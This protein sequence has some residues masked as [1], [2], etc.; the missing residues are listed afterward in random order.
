MKTDS[1]GLPKIGGL[2]VHS[3]LKTE[4]RKNH[5]AIAFVQTL[6]QR[7]V[8]LL[9][10]VICGYCATNTASAQTIFTN[11][12]TGTNPNTSNPYTTGQTVD[13]NI[14]VSGIGRG[15]GIVSANANDRYSASGWNSSFDA[16]DYFEWTLTP[17]SGYK[18][19]F[20][21]FVY[22]GQASGTGP[23]GFAFRASVDGFTANI[24][25]PAAAATT[26][27]LADSAYQ[28]ITEAITFRLYGFG[29]SQSGGTFSVNNF[30]FNGTVVSTCIIPTAFNVTGGG[31][32]CSGGAGVPIGL[33]NSEPGVNYQLFRS[34]GTIAVGAFVEG[35]G[36]AISFGNQ[37][38]EDTYTVVATNTTGNCTA[39]M[40]GSAVVTVTSPVTPSVT[41]SANPGTTTCAGNPVIFTATPVNGGSSPTYVWKTNG[42]QDTSVPVDSA[43][44]TNSNLADGETIDCQMTSS[45]TCVTTPTA[46]APQ[47]TMTIT[48]SVTPSVSVAANQGTTICAGSPV[49]FTATP[50]NGGSSPVYVWKTNGVADTSVPATSATYTN[51]SLGN[52]D[53]IDCQLISNDPCASPATADALQISMTVNATVTPSVTIE[54]NPGSTICPDSSVTFTATPVNG[55]VAPT[56]Q[57]RTNGV[58]VTDATSSTWMTSTLQNGDVVTV[59]VTP[60]GE[61]CVSP[62]TAVSEGITMTV[63]PR[64]TAIVSGT[65]AICE[66]SSADL[67]ATL[68]GNQPWSITWSDGVTESGITTSPHTRSVSPETNT[69]YTITA[70]SDANCSFTGTGSA[71]ITVNSFELAFTALSENMGTPSSTTLVND[72]TGWQSEPPITFSSTSSVQTDVRTTTASTGYPGASG[73]GNV[74]FGTAGGADRD[75]II[76]GINTMGLTASQLQFGLLATGS[77]PFVV[78]VSSDG[79]NWT[80]LTVPQPGSLNT[81]TLTTASGTIPAVPNLRIK[82]SKNSAT[83]QYRL[84]DVKLID[85]VDSVTI[86]ASGP[87]TFCDGGSVTLTA[88]GGGVSYLWSTSET[89][90]SITVNSSGTYSVTVFDAN[91]CSSTADQTV[92]VSSLPAVSVNSATICAGASAT[93]TATT[94]AS[95]PSYLWS[96]GGETT[97]SILVSPEVTTVYSVIVTDGT[98]GCASAATNTV[99]VNPLP[100]VAITPTATNAECGSTFTLTADVSGD[101]P[102]IY[103]WYDNLTNAI[104]N[105]T[106]ITLTLSDVDATVAGHYSIVVNG[107]FCSASALATVSVTDTLGPVIT[108][109]GPN[110]ATNE[111]HAAYLD[112]GAAASDACAGVV[113]V[114]TN[115]TVDVNVPGIYT[116]TYTSDDGNGNTNTATRTVYVQD[117]IAPLITYYFTNLTLSANGSC[118][119]LM[120]DV[121]GPDYVLAE[122][123]CGE[124]TITQT[125][126]N[127]ALLNLGPNEVV[128]IVTDSAGNTAYATNTIN[129]VDLTPPALVLNGDNPLT[130]ECHSPFAD[131]GASA[132]DNCSG[133]LAVTTNGVVDANVPGSY[134]IEYRAADAA[135]N[136]VTNTRVVNVVDTVPPVIV[137]GTNKAV[138]CGV[139]W[140]FDEPTAEDACAGVNVIVAI[141]DTV[142]NG[143]V[144]TRTWA[145]SDPAGNTNTCSQSVAVAEATGVVVVPL[146]ANPATNECHTTYSDPGALATTCDGSVAVSTNGTVDV[147]TP[148]VYTITYTA[149]DGDGHTNSATRTVYVVDTTAPLITFYFTNLTLN[150]DASCE[151][152]MPDVTDTNYILAEDLCSGEVTITQSPTNG[153]ALVL[154]T[155][156][157]VLAVADSAGNTAYS[158]N[159]IVVV[160]ATGPVVTINGDNPLTL[161]CHADFV[162]PGAIASDGCSGVLAVN[163]NGVVD[164]NVPGSYAIE[165]TATDSAGNSTTNTRIVNVVDATAPVVTVLGDNPATNE[166]H[167]VYVDAGATASDACAGSVAV[168][169]NHTVDANTPGVYTITYTAD[170]GNGNTNSATR[171]VYVVDT[172]PPQIVLCATNRTMEVVDNCLLALPDFTGELSVTDSCSEVFIVQNPTPGTLVGVGQLLVTFT[173]SDAALNSSTCS[174]LLNVTPPAGANTNLS[175]SEFMAKNTVVITDD[176]GVYSDWIEIHNAGSC[177]VN[178]AGWSLTDDSGSLAKWQFPATNIGPGQFM[179][180]WASDRNLSIPGAPLHTNFKLSDEGEYL[181]LVQPN[182]TPISQFSPVFPPQLP[183]VS[184]GLP[185]DRT[186]NTFLAAATPGAANSVATNFMGST[187]VIISEFMAKNTFTL[188]DEDGDYS[189]WIEIYNAGDS[190]VD[191]NGWSL[192]DN[193]AQLTKWRFPATNIA[194]GQFVLVWASDKNRRV[195]GAPLH[196]NFKMSDE[197]E[198]LALVQ[199]DG[200]TIATEF[201]PTFPPQFPDVSFG[202]PSGGGTYQFLASSTPGSANSSGTNFIVADLEFNPGRGWYKH[203]VSVTIGT[204]TPDV[205]IYWTTDG[206]VPSP[207]N[208]SL[209]TGPLLFSDTTVLRAAAYRPGYLPTVA[210]H[211]YVFPRQVTNQTGAGFPS[212]WGISYAGVR[213]A[214]YTCNSNL[215]NDPRWGSRMSTAL[216]TLP[217]LSV[218]MNQDDMF[219]TNGIYSN[220]FGDGVEWE[221]PCSVEYFRP[222]GENYFGPEPGLGFQI[223]CG[224]RIQGSSSRDPTF[225]PKHNLRLLFKQ[226]YDATPMIYDLYPGSP[227]QEFKTLVLHASSGDHWFGVGATAQMHRDQWVADTQE[228]IGDFGT[229]GVYVHLYINGLY[230]G[231]YNVGERPDVDYAVSY[232]GG[233]K[234]DYDIFNGE[235]LKDGTTNALNEMLTIARAGITN[236]VAW[237]NICHYLDVPSFINYL[238]INWYTINHDFTGHNY[239]LNGSVSHG[240]PFHFITW[241]AESTFDVF[242]TV[243]LDYPIIDAT[244]NG[245][246]PVCVLY[247]SLRQHP[248]FRRLVG[249]HAQRL[250]FNQGALTPQR[251]ADRWMKRA[252]ELDTAIIAESVRWGITNWWA[253]AYW[254]WDWKLNTRDTWITEQ[255]YLMTN[256]FP[257][258]TGILIDQLRTAGLYPTLDAPVFTPHGGIIITSLPVTLSPPATAILYYTTN[259]TDPRL[260]DGSVSPG[261]FALPAEQA[262]TLTENT[263]LRARAFVDDTWSALTEA[264][265]IRAD[266][267]NLRMNSIVRRSDNNVEVNL[268]AWPGAAYTLRATTNV[269]A[270]P[271]TWEAIATIIPFP[272]GTS[273]FVDT[274]A[275]NNPARF[276]RLTWP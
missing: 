274:T 199:P 99:T 88:S 214:Y 166:C 158:T 105:E 149:D 156:E 171:T 195:P 78:E 106:N 211:S 123:L 154:G 102:L 261:A 236:D 30:T 147:N 136:S 237:S 21:S 185:S 270:D 253:T 2:V 113:A 157:V 209:Y 26:I 126:T 163:T 110:P 208:G 205:S 57:W 150:A 85:V 31:S 22:T 222:D 133:L 204:A 20:V 120:P 39:N 140:S 201:S 143:N 212:T 5:F 153:A 223:N 141:V 131:P 179:V 190:A 219:G 218:V 10:A 182:G 169:T 45:L 184:Y 181:A 130:V 42:V 4:R 62:L 49:I 174:L 24:G 28:N 137:C 242:R 198:Y 241:D 104:P 230:W 210:T 116:V 148:G 221:R 74:F 250:L 56:Y 16:D 272:D 176:F 96:P 46:D 273:T 254:G 25:T 258:R 229:H 55:G 53:T 235:E 259:G 48:T 178:L 125:P 225:T 217:T 228:E 66:G 77:D 60:S 129:V 121:T 186:T 220:P 139:V 98:T 135:G 231:V 34:S 29:A 15:P 252:R 168:S 87:T 11:P 155:N 226:I 89:T 40:I 73:G 1:S 266:E 224:I 152:V 142:T 197:G 59:V 103:Q 165:Y 233:N 76:G 216:R 269:N 114:S 240:M 97:A 183:D 257:N 80:A 193:P 189:D 37:S 263:L 91:G 18:I 265:Y 109:L 68:T 232:F 81:W 19:N 271:T 188:A 172:V 276:Y 27:S 124:I 95:N 41:V 84:D 175:I 82:F 94:D 108:V 67:T 187:N 52:G 167:A 128:L 202:S 268:E 54:A 90:P 23:T 146:G 256:W 3:I 164:S 112:A 79:I 51:S 203:G 160:D 173:A 13:V 63:N 101:G 227:V 117:S 93:L 245:F 9:V 44:Y 144:L 86:T 132:S 127:D 151:A 12:I 6:F 234:S 115:S 275:T 244:E 7:K 248:E 191:L 243:P 267:V 70:V 14:T 170:D 177:A 215:V 200:I 196:T 47:L 238:L 251:S 138:E 260:P 36:S 71:V 58:P 162:D 17:N 107:P 111:C 249:D 33:D 38:E 206:S 122:D 247:A 43:S 239:W 8:C 180:V 72:Y 35:T 213:P 255:T 61:I 246:A 264:S 65:T 192:T 262:I 100:V 83:A 50:I 207:T 32:Y 145:I 69:T 118:Q 159:T 119:A 194:A 134:V 92:T 75:F 64:P 161:E